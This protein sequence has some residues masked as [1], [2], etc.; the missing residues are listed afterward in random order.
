MG[1]TV[2]AQPRSAGERT[3][4]PSP[5][6]LAAAALLGLVSLPLAAASPVPKSAILHEPLRLAVV[7]GDG[8]AFE[9]EALRVKPEVA[10]RLPLAILTHGSPRE[11]QARRRMSAGHMSFQAEELARRGYV[12]VVV[13]RRGYGTSE[14]A[15]AESSGRCESP[16]HERAARESARDLRAALLALVRMPDV[17][18]ERVIVIGQS[19][20]GI[21]TVA[22]AADPPAGLK[23]VINFAGG[24]GSRGPND[25]CREDRLVEAYRTLGKTARVPSL[26]IYTENDSYF[27]PDL[28]KRMFTAYTSQ[29]G[30]GEFRLLPAFA[31][32]G[33]ALFARR[34]GVPQWRPLLDSFLKRNAL[35][36]WDTPPS[37]PAIA[38]LPPPA[39]LAPSHRSH[40][41]R[42]LESSDN[43]AFALSLNGRFA[44]R[45]GHY[46]L[47]AASA[48]ALEACG[49]ASCRVVAENDTLVQA[50]RDASGHSRSGLNT[51]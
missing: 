9:L 2:G 15:W 5:W 6:R 10:G 30:T 1:S 46:T 11:A 7:L 41:L 36:T 16:D 38:Q 31:E 49:Q 20:G 18:P 26:W 33:H 13:M 39:E 21:G 32:D 25:V 8:A 35:P 40:W 50:P 19:A 47:Q 42:Y 14:G 4:A 48:A 34:G 43:K 12:A 44:W 51:E 23:A 37:E 22:L 28:A 29:G 45:S 17:D 24:R 3:R 27:G